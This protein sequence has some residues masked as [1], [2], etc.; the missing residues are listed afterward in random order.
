MRTLLWIFFLATM[1][2]VS[3]CAGIGQ[4]QTETIDIAQVNAVEH[5]AAQQGVKVIWIH[6]PQKRVRV[7]E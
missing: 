6:Y 3:A 7:T 4:R 2:G 1:L 5:V